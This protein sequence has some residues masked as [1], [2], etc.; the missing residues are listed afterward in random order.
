MKHLS[1]RQISDAVNSL[2]PSDKARLARNLV[3]SLRVESR[4]SADKAWAR[5]AERRMALY[6]SGKLKSFSLETVLA[7]MRSKI[8]K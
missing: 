1:Y 5:E 4:R 8:S 7:S 2:P 3:R 6:E